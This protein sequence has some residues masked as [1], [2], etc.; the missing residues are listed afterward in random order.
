MY[1]TMCLKFLKLLG[2]GDSREVRIGTCPRNTA[3]LL[4][5]ML[6]DSDAKGEYETSGLAGQCRFPGPRHIK[7]QPL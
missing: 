3:P 7:R 5:V 4:T 2:P 6:T 1:L